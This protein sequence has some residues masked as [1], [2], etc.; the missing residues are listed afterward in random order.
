MSDT[1]AIQLQDMQEVAYWRIKLNA[2]ALHYAFRYPNFQ[3]AALLCNKNN[4][5][6]KTRKRKT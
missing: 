5:G 4:T 3:M 2:T 1:I 6:T